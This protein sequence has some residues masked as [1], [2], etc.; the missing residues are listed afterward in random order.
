MA[1]SGA[2][3][4]ITIIGVIKGEDIKNSGTT[5]IIISG[6]ENVAEPE[7][8]SIVSEGKKNILSIQESKIRFENI[9]ISASKNDLD[10]LE[11]LRQERKGDRFAAAVTNNFTAIWLYKDSSV[12]LGKNA[13]IKNVGLVCHRDNYQYAS[14][15]ENTSF[16]M[17][18]N[19]QIIDCGVDISQPVIDVTNFSMKD[20]SVIKV[21][22]GRCNIFGAF[23]MQGNASFEN[24]TGNIECHKFIMSGYSTIKNCKSPNVIV[25][26]SIESLRDH[27][28]GVEKEKSLMNENATITNNNSNACIYLKE[29][30]LKISGNAKITN[31]KGSGIYAGFNNMQ[32]SNNLEI[33]GNA[34]IS[35]NYSANNGGG[36]LINNGD[37]NFV[38]SGGKITGNTAKKGG[39]IYFYND[40]DKVNI[41]ISGGVINGNKAEYGAGIYIAEI[42]KSTTAKISITSVSITNNEAEFVGGGIYCENNVSFPATGIKFS[43]NKA[44]DGDGENIFKQ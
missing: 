3:K 13:I 22:V 11:K 4:K 12:I 17:I 21:I 32:Y 37:I 18:S 30:D 41:T 27:Y 43:G 35:N 7:Q 36:I 29:A 15:A 28:Y 24:N 14:W 25:V 1:K 42:D 9:T 40:A 20:Q 33:T 31:N 10:K 23:E 34:E 16:T 26:I 19:S 5:E 38:M 44:G 8:A 2:V 39:G 6:K